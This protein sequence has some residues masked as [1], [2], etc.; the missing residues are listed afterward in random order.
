MLALTPQLRE[1]LSMNPL[2]AQ[3]LPG[4]AVLPS[5][6]GPEYWMRH[7]SLNAVNVSTSRSHHLFII[8]SLTFMLAVIPVEEQSFWLFCT[9]L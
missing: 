8:I 1:V 7:V 9:L 6:C 5:D 2:E 3:I 4:V